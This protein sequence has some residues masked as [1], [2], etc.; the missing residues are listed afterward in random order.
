L[1]HDYGKDLIAHGPLYKEHKIV[2]GKVHL[3]FDYANGLKARGGGPLKRFEI[4]GADRMWHW[5]DADIQGGSIVVSSSKVSE[6][7]AVRYAWCSNPE[8]ANL[9]NSEGL[10][11]SVFR[12]DDWKIEGQ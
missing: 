11:A 8:G 2:G 3:S 7:A 9:V 5:A 6:P 10:P 1:K 12:T 4:A